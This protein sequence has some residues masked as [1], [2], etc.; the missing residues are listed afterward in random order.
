MST[1]EEQTEQENIAAGE[2]KLT[3]EGN[4]LIA[5]FMAFGY[6]P[7]TDKGFMRIKEWQRSTWEWYDTEQLEFHESW[8]WLMLVGKRI[9]EVLAELHAKMPKHSA[10]HGHVI[11][12]DIHCAVTTYNINKAWIAIVSF[13]RW[14]NDF[15]NMKAKLDVEPQ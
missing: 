11:E 13:V 15:K 3:T 10:C 6:N 4:K 7:K 9:R 8:D 5:E 14:Y 2:E 1:F 12:V